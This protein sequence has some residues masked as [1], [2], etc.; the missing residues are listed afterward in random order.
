MCS[1]HKAHKA[2]EKVCIYQWNLVHNEQWRE[3]AWST[4]PQK[5]SLL[6]LSYEEEGGGGNICLHKS[7]PPHYH[8]LSFSFFQNRDQQLE[9]PKAKSGPQKDATWHPA[10]GTKTKEFSH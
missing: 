1:R 7:G 5:Q 8:L 10:D 2:L 6:I 4:A 3:R 9:A